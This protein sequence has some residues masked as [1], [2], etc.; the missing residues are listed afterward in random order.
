MP[1]RAAVFAISLTASCGTVALAGLLA[2]SLQGWFGVSDL[3]FLVIWFVPLSLIVAALAAFA[4]QGVSRWP[5]LLRYVGGLGVGLALGFLWTFCVA[6]LLGPWWGAV[7]L[8][9]AMCGM[10]G[11]ASGVAGGIVL[12][13]GTSARSRVASI[14]GLLALVVAGVVLGKP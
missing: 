11:G 14:G 13:P 6:L 4:F 10:A 3:T 2:A 1:V 9:A 8:P 7:S 12:G 5:L